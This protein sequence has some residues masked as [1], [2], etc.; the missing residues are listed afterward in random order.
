VGTS[1]VFTSY[2]I[3]VASYSV[4]VVSYFAI[5]ASCS[6][7]VISY[8]TAAAFYEESS[9]GVRFYSKAGSSCSNL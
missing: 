7:I 6:I 3:T 2:F 9:V 8:S 1:I 5:V 4:I